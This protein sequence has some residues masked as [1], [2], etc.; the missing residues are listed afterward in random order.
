MFDGS[1]INIV[2]RLWCHISIRRRAQF[3]LLML[4]MVPTALAEIISIGAA[5][6]FLGVLTSPDLVFSHASVQP[7]INAFG[8]V[9][10]DQLLLP[11]TIIFGSM[12]VLAGAMRLILLWSN[13]RLS[14]L[15]GSDISISIYRRTLYQPYGVHCSRNSSELISGISNKTSEVIQAITMIL[16]V[17][18]S[19]VMLFSILMALL[20]VDPIVASSAFF[21]FGLIYAIT[22]NVTRKQLSINSRIISREST[23]V[24]KSLQEGL[25]GIRDILIDGSQET[26]CQ[27]YRNSDLPLRKAIGS[28]AFISSSPRYAVESLSMVLIAGL[29]YLLAKDSDGAAKSIP[30]LGALALGAQRLLPVLQQAY[31]AWTNIRSGKNSLEDALALLDQPLPA[32]AD[33]HPPLPMQFLHSIEL[34]NVKFRYGAEMPWVLSNIDIN[35]PKGGR[36]GFIGGTGSGK[37]TLL[38]L[39]MGLLLPTEGSLLIDGQTITPKNYR[40]W[41]LNIAHVPQDIFLADTTVEENIAFGVPKDEID[42]R[43]VRESARQAQIANTIEAWPEKYKT[44]V[45]ERGARISGGQRQ[46]IGIARALYKNAKVIIFDEATSALDSETEQA[47]TRVIENFN[48]DLTLLIIAHRTTTLKFCS[49]VIELGDGRVRRCGSYKEIIG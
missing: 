27:V 46:R 26:F 6:P 34:K 49:Q 1:L 42:Q 16:T 30:I 10:P 38:D 29:A 32:Y 5:I 8:V 14:F 20:S 40:A 4:L 17:I 3:G 28:S 37:S 39:L 48:Q 41:Q 25:G 24:I 23:N 36:I 45:G 43:R 18:T 47:I 2:H 12:A 31:A 22:I 15:I 19:T 21:G 13:T 44:V 7:I 35:I 11:L 33:Q 9:R